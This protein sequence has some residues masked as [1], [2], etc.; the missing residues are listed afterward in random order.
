MKKRRKKFILGSLIVLLLVGYLVYT[1]LRDTMGYYMTVSELKA[2]GEP[3][4]GE[5]L[6][7]SGKVV[8]GSISW[9]PKELVLGFK[10]ADDRESIDV[11]YKGVVPDTFKNGVDVVVEGKYTPEGVFQA[12]VLLPKCPSKYLPKV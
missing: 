1:G 4:Y 12:S 5:V 10:I 2:K 9:N 11:V 3:I 7:L 8:D 6:R